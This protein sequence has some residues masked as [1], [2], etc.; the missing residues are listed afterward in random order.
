MKGGTTALFD[1]LALHPGVNACSI[2]EPTFFVSSWNY[3]RGINWYTSLWGG[4]D[5]DASLLM[6]AS[7]DYTKWPYVDGVPA[8]IHNQYRDNVRFL[9]VLRHPMRRIESHHLHAHYTGRESGCVPNSEPGRRNYDLDHGISPLA[10]AISHYAMQIDQYTRY[11]PASSIK[12]IIFEELVSASDRVLE[13]VCRF[14]DIDLNQPIKLP[15]AGNSES[16]RVYRKG[17][18]APILRKNK[19]LRELWQTLMPP[20]TR[21]F[22]Y[23]ITTMTVKKT[24]RFH[25]LRAEESALKEKLAADLIRLRDTYGVDVRKHW[26]LGI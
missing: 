19:T 23:G 16:K 15:H 21:D 25:L 6:E 12:I 8:L 26:Q 17:L 14:L 22:I 7:T 11:F 2:K 9:Y 18:S 20:T 3:N 1:C 4:G 13:E 10:I 24:G 5:R